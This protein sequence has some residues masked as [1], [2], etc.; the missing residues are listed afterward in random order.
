MIQPDD[1]AIA[2]LKFILLCFECMAGLQINFHKSE[3]MVLGTTS[4]AQ[5]RIANMLNYKLGSF[6]FTYLDFS[7]VAR[8]SRHQIGARFR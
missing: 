1:L 5:Q 4:T 8:L 3:V 6:P 7:L 2:N